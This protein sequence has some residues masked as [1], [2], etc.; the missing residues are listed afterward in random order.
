MDE[1]TLKRISIIGVCVC[2][3]LLY[4][5]TIQPSSLH[6]NIGEI[7]RSFTGK[8]VNVTGVIEAVSE[9]KGNIFID[10]K[11]DTGK[12]KVVLWEETIDSID[13]NDLNKG[14]LVKGNVINI[15]G[16]VQLYRGELEVIPLRGDVKIIKT[17]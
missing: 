10:L 13:M 1:K 2:L 14:E 11:D 15:I 16:E 17:L 12:I 3:V 8:V 7:D 6:V 9:S 5:V 4:I